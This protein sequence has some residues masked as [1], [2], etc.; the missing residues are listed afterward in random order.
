MARSDAIKKLHEVVRVV[1]SAIEADIPADFAAVYEAAR[2]VLNAEDELQ[3]VDHGEDGQTESK[4]VAKV[5]PFGGIGFGKMIKRTEV[6]SEPGAAIEVTRLNLTPET[7]A[8]LCVGDT[9]IQDLPRLVPVEPQRPTLDQ[10]P[11]GDDLT[12]SHPSQDHVSI[13]RRVGLWAYN[14]RPD[15]CTGSAYA[16]ADQCIVLDADP[17]GPKT[18]GDLMPGDVFH[19][20]EEWCLVCCDDPDFEDEIVGV[21]LNSKQ[22]ASLS[23]H[24]PITGP[25]Y[26]FEIAD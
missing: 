25:V 15:G 19:D 20:G 7:K 22:E 16:L 6:I 4:S 18:V 9:P 17:I 3:T 14:L 21:H 24:T 1:E 11:E 2:D 26:R 10:T 13:V 23:K 12:V 8:R 5:D